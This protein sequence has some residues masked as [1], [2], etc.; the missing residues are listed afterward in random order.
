MADVLSQ[1]EID[2]LLAAMASG[3][4]IEEDSAG[5]FD[6]ES[7]V[8]STVL[9]DSFK[10]SD[11]DIDILEN[12]HKEYTQIISSSMFK[13]LNT[14]VCLESIQE[15]RYEEFMRS[16]PCPAVLTVFRLNPL[17]GYLLFETS[18]S[19]VV[20]IIDILSEEDRSDKLSLENF[21]ENDKNVSMQITGNFIQCLEKT[22]SKVLSVKSEVEYLEIDPDK[23]KI[24]P[25]N[26]HI[27]LLSFSISIGKVNTFFNICIPYSSIEKYSGKLEIKNT[28]SQYELHNNFNSTS[29]NIKAILGN[30]Q[31]SL[32]E[33]MNLKK[34]TIL[35]INKGY[36]NK[37]SILVE[38]KHCFN[39]EVGLIRN[40]KAVKIVDCIDKDV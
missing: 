23:I 8:P 6:N 3:E 11:K 20:E 4:T 13:N 26:E 28:I 1:S 31:L 37:V 27:A 10:F 25:N 33:T 2:A 15:I 12:I 5:N 7:N 39:G 34:G 22:W 21:S 32:R 16:I 35:N 36:E 19:L 38:E 30:I 17:E 14:K 18:P 40:R 29:L 9:E 24:F